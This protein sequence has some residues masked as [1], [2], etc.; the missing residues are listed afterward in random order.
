[1]KLM[2]FRQIVWCLGVAVI[3]GACGDGGAAS[4]PLP[5]SATLALLAGDIGG[6][7]NVDGFGPACA[8]GGYVVVERKR[9]TDKSDARGSE[10]WISGCFWTS[11]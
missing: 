1:M 6:P 8:V 2:A 9:V 7:G 4:V 10:S 5:P 11:P 3:L